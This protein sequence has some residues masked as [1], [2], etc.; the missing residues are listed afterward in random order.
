MPPFFGDVVCHHHLDEYALSNFKE[1]DKIV[2]AVNIADLMARKLNIGF[3]GPLG[4]VTYNRESTNYL[5][6]IITDLNK[7]ERH[8][9][10]R[11][12]LFEIFSH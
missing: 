9:M 10:E 11:R 7:I 5:G 8:V 1:E 2:A 3:S 4:Q 12:E 6:L